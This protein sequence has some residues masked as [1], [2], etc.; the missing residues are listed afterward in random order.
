QVRAKHRLHGKSLV[1]H[2]SML[3]SGSGLAYK[4]T[5]VGTRSSTHQTL[6]GLACLLRSS[7]RVIEP[8][9]ARGL[10]ALKSRG[11]HPWRTQSSM[12]AP[13]DLARDVERLCGR[14]APLPCRDP[15]ASAGFRLYGSA[16]LSGSHK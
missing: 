16:H 8:P 7:W 2:A 5:L 13:N 1:Q 14:S 3:T 11:G 12:K 15:K 6:V 9:D 10:I 4:D